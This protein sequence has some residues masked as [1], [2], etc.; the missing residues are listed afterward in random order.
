[1]LNLIQAD[2]FKLRKS[3]AVKILFGITTV[4]AAIMAMMAYLIPQGKIDAN[5]TGLGFLFSDMNMMSILGAV[6]AGIFICGDFDNKTIHYAIANG[7]S[8]GVVI[9]SKAIVFCVA[10]AF[11]LLPYAILTGIALST[12]YEFSMGSVSIGFL[13]ILTSDSG[14]VFSASEIGKLLVVMFALMI[15]YMAQLSISVAFALVLKKPVF[16]V[17]IYYGLT[18][19]CAQLVRLKDSYAI[20]DSIF[21][22]TPYGG[23]YTFLTLNSEMGDIFKAIAISLIFMIV[24]FAVTYSIFRK[25]EIK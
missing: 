17:A 9:A 2:L 13:N 4:S 8:R 19:F 15:V 24:V 14:T 11:M 10:I 22:C 5:M 1:M 12:G 6:I 18:I 23:N 16:V 20:F 25:S 7:S 3:T 21:S